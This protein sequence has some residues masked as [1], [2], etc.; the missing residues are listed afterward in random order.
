MEFIIRDCFEWLWSPPAEQFFSQEVIIL[1]F[2][3][4]LE[5]NLGFMDML[6]EFLAT[7]SSINKQKAHSFSHV[8][9]AFTLSALGHSMNNN[10]GKLYEP[11]FGMRYTNVMHKYECDQLSPENKSNL[12]RT[13]IVRK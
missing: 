11:I 9:V 2:G 5:L 6:Q 13:F 12:S 3:E 1:I 4:T 10:L 7:S 8:Q